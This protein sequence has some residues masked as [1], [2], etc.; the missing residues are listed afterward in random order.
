VGISIGGALGVVKASNTQSVDSAADATET[1][2][3]RR[4]IVDT[5]HTTSE[6]VL[7]PPS[8]HGTQAQFVPSCSIARLT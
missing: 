2:G 3:S 4:S 1:S 7:R 8:P 6:I 5:V